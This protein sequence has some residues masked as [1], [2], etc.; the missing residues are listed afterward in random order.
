VINVYQPSVGEAELSAVREVFQTA[1]VGRGGRVDAFEAEFARRLGADRDRV[2]STNSCTEAIFIGLELLGL[3]P[4]D[5]VVLPT[6]SFVGAANAIASRGARPVFCD[7]DPRTLNPTAEQV[8]ERITPRTAGVLLLHYAGQPGE[9]AAIAELCR[10]RGIWLLEDAANAQASSVDGRPCGTFG[11]IGV[12][13][14]DWGKIATSV[15]GGIL[16]CRTPELAARAAKVA[17][18]GLEQLSGFAEAY[19]TDTRWWEFEISSFSRR[20]IMNDVQAAIGLVQLGRLDGFIER[21]REIA[22]HYDRALRDVPGLQ[23]PP[24]LPAGHVSSSYMYWVQ[25]APGI[26]DRVARRLYT[27]GIYTTF[28]YALLH[29]VQAYGSAGA[30]LPGAEQAAAT[31]LCIPN[32]QALT[33]AEVEL[34]AERLARAVAEESRGRATAA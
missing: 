5:E 20:S 17:Y 21:R 25:L 19:K 32:H 27:E 13:S 26:R 29:R 30:H 7:V 8:A 9:I 33:D 16:C 2:T 28:R 14:F 15:D 10:D 18:F 34:V 1:W 6:V 23:V 11:D 12:W 24:P 3:Q 22:E 31:T 4:G